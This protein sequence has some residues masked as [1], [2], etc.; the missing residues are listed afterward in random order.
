MTEQ[1]QEWLSFEEAAADLGVARRTLH[2][3]VQDGKL[4][5]YKS[6]VGGRTI[7]KRED[8]KTF[9]QPR[10]VVKGG[11]VEAERASA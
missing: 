11:E 6:P 9:K 10:L 7:F 8:L 5:A 4:P 2:K 3:Y 1:E